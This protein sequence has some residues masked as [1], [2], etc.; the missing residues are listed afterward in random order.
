MI[1]PVLLFFIPFWL[2]QLIKHDMYLFFSSFFLLQIKLQICKCIV[3]ILRLRSSCCFSHL[4]PSFFWKCWFLERGR[5]SS[6][7][8]QKPVC[9]SLPYFLTTTLS[10][11]GTRFM[12][13]KTL[14]PPPRSCKAGSW[15]GWTLQRGTNGSRSGG[16]SGEERR[17][18]ATSCLTHPLPPWR[19]LWTFFLTLI[20]WGTIIAWTSSRRTVRGLRTRGKRRQFDGTR[21]AL[22]IIYSGNCTYLNWHKCNSMTGVN[23]AI[24]CLIKACR[25]PSTSSHHNKQYTSLLQSQ[26]VFRR[27]S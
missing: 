23:F 19:P 21:E 16:A 3:L 17:S 10:P 1:I 13:W 18:N 4:P 12:C 11:S 25:D 20:S 2:A 15:T 8:H 7:L 26:L 24:N 9:F 14:S 5:E 6:D 27:Q 22:M